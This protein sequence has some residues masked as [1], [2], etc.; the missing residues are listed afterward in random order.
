MGSKDSVHDCLVLKQDHHDRGHSAT[1]FLVDDNQEAE[2]KNNARKKEARG[3][4]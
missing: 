3:Q 4:I 2:Q 1:K